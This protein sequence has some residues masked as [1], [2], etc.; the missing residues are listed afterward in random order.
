MPSIKLLR[1]IRLIPE[2]CR[3]GRE[4]MSSPGKWKENWH[5]KQANPTEGNVIRPGVGYLSQEGRANRTGLTVCLQ[6]E[7]PALNGYVD[8]WKPDGSF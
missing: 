5:F 2:D 1:L 8:P 4:R 3:E 7:E 6:W